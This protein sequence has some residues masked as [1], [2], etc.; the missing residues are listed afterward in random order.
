LGLGFDKVRHLLVSVPL[1][2][3]YTTQT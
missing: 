2:K 1:E 3:Y